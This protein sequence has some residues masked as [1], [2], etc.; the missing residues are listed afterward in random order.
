MVEQAASGA[1]VR[2]VGG[3]VA[4][5]EALLALRDLAGDRAQLTLIAP[6]PDFVYK[7]LLVEEPFGLGP[8]KQ[9][10]RWPASSRMSTASNSTTGPS[11]TTTTR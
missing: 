5:V 1:H 9:Y 10:S 6:E 2:I 3:G 8:A 4:G 7:P 11:S